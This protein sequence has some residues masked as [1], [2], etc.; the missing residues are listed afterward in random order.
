MRNRE[1]DGDDRIR[2]HVVARVR[3]DNPNMRIKADEQPPNYI[4]K[5]VHDR[6]HNDERGDPERDSKNRDP[7]ND[8][9]QSDASW[10]KQV[11]TGNEQAIIHS[12]YRTAGASRRRWVKT[13]RRAGRRDDLASMECLQNKAQGLRFSANLPGAMSYIVLIFLFLFLFPAQVSHAQAR[14]DSLTNV[15]GSG[16]GLEVLI[17]N[18]GFGLGAYLQQ[19]VGRHTSATLAFHI[20]SEKSER[21]VRFLG[22][23]QNFIPD[24]ANYFLRA[25]ILIGV[26]RRLWQAFIEDNFRPYA[27]IALGPSL[28]W[29]YPYFDDENTNG[30]YDPGERRYEGF[31]SLFKGSFRFGFGGMI[32]L[33]AQFGENPRTTQGM[34]VG[35]SFNYFLDPIQLLEPDE[36]SPA[37]RFFGTPTIS[38]TFGRLFSGRRSDIKSK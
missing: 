22:V 27:Q 37:I 17:T 29:I 25:P 14:P 6:E 2:I 26:Q 34:R 16:A 36:S 13:G 11:P 5:P 10:T 3:G 20:G 28:G 30:T 1:G 24:K 23:S 18:S 32:G 8:G 35:Y 21:E 7:C 15:Y 4:G 38:I 19:A 31:G 12:Q 9:D 33:G